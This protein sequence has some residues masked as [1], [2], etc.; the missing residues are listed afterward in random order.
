MSKTATRL[1]SLIMLLQRQPNQKAADLADE[2][3]VS[4]RTLH[5]YFAML[6]EMGIPIYSE[7][8]P[9][10]GFSLVK[11][12]RMPPLVFT[13]EEAVAVYLGTSLVEEMWGRLYRDAAHGALA[14]LDNV[15]PDEQRHEIAWARRALFATGM[16]RTDLEDLA[17]IL[18]KLRRATRE[19]RQVRMRYQSRRQPETNM[20]E[21]DP[22]ALVHRWGWWY[23]IGKCHLRNAVRIFR[24]DRIHELCLLEA[25][26]Q[27][28]P[29]FDLQVYLANETQ[30]QPQVTARMRFIPEA[31]RAAFES[32]FYWETLEEQPD[33]SVIVSF[34]APDLEWA[35]STALAYGPIVEV[36]NPPELRQMLGK[37]AQ[38]VVQ[39]YD[40]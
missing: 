29:D 15:L 37:W 1:I 7:R 12:Y 38:A 25:T 20:R 31:R 35:A 11:G 10:G 5:R 33:G 19:H 4:V 34:A 6:D 39:R 30:A 17:P 40:I 26:F 21:L 9:Y 8:G 2:L 3:G 27:I 23:V 36:L 14:K 28:A 32:R 13:P 24:L 16:H 22:Y 18:E